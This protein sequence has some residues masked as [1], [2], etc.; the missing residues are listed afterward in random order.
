M[1]IERKKEKRKKDRKKGR[2]ERKNLIVIKEIL[3][4]GIFVVGDLRGC[5]RK[6]GF[7]FWLFCREGNYNEYFLINIYDYS[8]FFYR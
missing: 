4:N 6:L 5:F 3:V 1:N 8:L 2:E 7:K